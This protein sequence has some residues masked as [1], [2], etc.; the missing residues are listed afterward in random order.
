[1][2]TIIGRPQHT[3]GEPWKRR[4]GGQGF[5]RARQR[6]LRGLAALTGV[7]VIWIGEVARAWCIVLML[8]LSRP[9]YCRVTEFSAS[10]T[11]LHL[12][13]PDERANQTAF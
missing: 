3:A 7:V 4:D 9:C 6:L 11:L 5:Y 2:S 8:A 10:A 1:M 13:P 12:V